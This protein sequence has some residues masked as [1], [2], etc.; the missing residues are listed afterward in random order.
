MT[1]DGKEG[2]DVIYAGKGNDT[3][4]GGAGDDYI[5]GGLGTNTIVYN[6]GDGMDTIEL[7]KRE[8]LIFDVQGLSKANLFFELG[9]VDL[10]INKI[11]IQEDGSEELI[12]IFTIKNFSIWDTYKNTSA[13]AVIGGQTGSTV[14]GGLLSPGSS[15]KEYKPTI[16]A[17]MVFNGDEENVVDLVYDNDLYRILVNG[18]YTGKWVGEIIDASESSQGVKIDGKSGDDTII[19]SQHDDV[20]KGN[21]GNNRIVYNKEIFGDDIVKLTKGAGLT[22]DFSAL[23]EVTQDSLDFTRSG[24]DVILSYTTVLKDED[25]NPILDEDDELAYV[26][27]SVTVQNLATTKFATDKGTVNPLFADSTELDLKRDAY[28]DKVYI[29]KNYSG[30]LLGD[31]VDASGLL[32]ATNS[33]GRGLTIKTGYGNDVIKG[34]AFKDTIVGGAGDDILKGGESS[35]VT[36]EFSSSGDGND[37]IIDSGSRNYIKFTGFFTFEFFCI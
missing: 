31:N 33:K 4:I 8:N 25:G 2:I 27:S 24:K 29:T 13:T 35:Q 20:L 16:G 3:I 32:Q 22:L 18:D 19:G 9:D 37:T 7:T 23:P 6:N 17:T 26:T 10:V 5:K 30:T 36:Y 15:E 21:F 1:I 34:S 28:R 11:V 14:L 12:P